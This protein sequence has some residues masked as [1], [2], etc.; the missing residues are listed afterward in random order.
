MVLPNSFVDVRDV[1]A[2]KEMLHFVQNDRVGSSL[3]PVTRSSSWAVCARQRPQ[4]AIPLA[5]TMFPIRIMVV[6]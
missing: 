1:A 6:T 2:T 4:A 3:R 5:T